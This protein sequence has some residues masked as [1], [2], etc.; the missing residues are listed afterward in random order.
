MRKKTIGR[1][2]ILLSLLVWLT[3]R[4]THAISAMLG[5]I[6]CGD[7]YMQFVDGMVGDFSCGFNID[8]HLAYSLFTLFLLGILLY[9]SSL[10]ETVQREDNI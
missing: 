2:F 7:Q 1:F 6:I 8:M 5:K 10:K 3:D 9:Y 4:L